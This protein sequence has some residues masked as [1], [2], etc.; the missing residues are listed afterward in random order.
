MPVGKSNEVRLHVK[1]G[2]EG[3]RE[4]GGGRGTPQISKYHISPKKYAEKSSE[5][6]SAGAGGAPKKARHPARP[7]RSS[8]AFAPNPASF[9]PEMNQDAG[10]KPEIS[11]ATVAKSFV[12][13]YY[14][15][16]KKNPLS[17]FPF[18]FET[19]NFTRIEDS[20]E[21]TNISGKA[22]IYEALQSADF[23]SS[24]FR[25]MSVDSQDVPNGGVL[26]IV[27]GSLR[28]DREAP[29]KAFVQTFVLGR[30]QVSNDDGTASTALLVSNDVLRYLPP[31]SSRIPGSMSSE[32]AT[33]TDEA[34]A[35]GG[36]VAPEGKKQQAAKTLAQ[37][38]SADKS[39]SGKSAAAQKQASQARGGSAKAG[40][41]PASS[42]E[43]K[44]T[45][46]QKGKS[47]GGSGKASRSTRGS[48]QPNPKSPKGG[49]RK[50]IKGGK[51]GDA[52]DATNKP[53]AAGPS[54]PKTW[55]ARL[56]ASRAADA[57]PAKAQEKSQQKA[58]AAAAKPALAAATAVEAAG[59]EG[60]STV[61]K[62]TDASF[63]VQSKKRKKN[64]KAGRPG[65]SSSF[66]DPEVIAQSIY[67]SLPAGTVR[68]DIEACFA[69]FGTIRDVSIPNPNYSFVRFSSREAIEAVIKAKPIR[70]KGEEV[71]VEKRRVST[72]GR[73]EGRGRERGSGRGGR[74]NGG[75]SRGRGDRR[76]SGRG[77][78]R[79]RDR[80]G[81]S[82]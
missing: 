2:C 42:A 9:G 13:Q 10:R 37:R 43:T 46:Q 44:K 75:R 68:A 19:A 33:N 15:K 1:Y 25:I 41:A 59:K 72:K 40:T 24:K 48:K 55:A 74:P 18:Y 30:M 27:T 58:A 28:V 69:S 61:D 66:N 7:P 71:K 3:G 8:V 49:R 29:A 62:D 36:A 50:E 12:S 17:V 4:V 14:T 22:K 77:G 78:K 23:A 5:K 54:V 73:G 76:G 53:S 16:L 38:E 45:R 79:G 67:V 20:K 82:S 32:A 47:A 26:V 52:K 56:V 80:T 35:F 65:F 70:L 51:W 81:S 39:A 31:Q 21:A 57:P 11:A 6:L 63:T 64:R 60:P 34:A